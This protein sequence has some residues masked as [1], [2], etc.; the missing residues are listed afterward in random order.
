MG[1]GLNERGITRFMMKVKKRP[2]GCWLWTG[3]MT[4]RSNQPKFKFGGV[5]MSAVR[6]SYQMFRGRV[7]KGLAVKTTCATRACVNPRHLYVEKL[8]PP[9]NKGVQ[10][11]NVRLSEKSASSIKRL[12]K[13]PRRNALLI[14]KR[15]KISRRH[16]YQIAQGLYWKS[17]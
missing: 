7:P 6:C 8:T 10:N 12:M 5:S 4:K 13:S 3:A 14:S 16:C 2:S 11:P 17:L 1:S 15:F 9:E